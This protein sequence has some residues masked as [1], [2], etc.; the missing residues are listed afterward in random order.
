MHFLASVFFTTVFIVEKGDIGGGGT[1]AKQRGGIDS[2][3]RRASSALIYVV[4]P[5]GMSLPLHPT[6]EVILTH[7]LVLVALL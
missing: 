1:E 4:C 7:I 3:I 2:C 5:K 6:R